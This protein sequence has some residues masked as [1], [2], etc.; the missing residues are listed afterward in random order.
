MLD[1]IL[2]GV[3]KPGRY[4]GGE[5][6][7][8]KKDFYA[9]NIKFALCFP[10]LYEIGMSNLGI[11]ILY[12]ILNGIPDVSCERFFSPAKDMEDNLRNN[13][14]EIFSLESKKPLKDFDLV[15]FSLGH[16]LGYTNVLNILDLGGVPL[17]ASKRSADF[18]LVIGG[19]PC[20]L[21]PEPMHEFFD[22]FVIGEAEEAIVEIVNL[23]RGLK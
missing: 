3:M 10:D 15:G 23:Y 12:G 9:S 1:N 5:W 7:A 4:I 2:S 18:P 13:K 8:S 20:T 19:G 17:R 16:E 6:N 22:F 21:N 11:R 14:A